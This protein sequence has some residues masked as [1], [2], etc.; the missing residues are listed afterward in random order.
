MSGAVPLLHL[1][2]LVTWDRESVTLFT[3]S[4]T[5]ITLAGNE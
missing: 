4:H 3:S 2:A 1:H 5:L